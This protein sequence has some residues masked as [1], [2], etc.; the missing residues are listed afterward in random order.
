[1]CSEWPNEKKR[2][3]TSG[4]GFDEMTCDMEVLML[5]RKGPTRARR[6][7]WRVQGRGAA[8]GQ[9]NGK[10]RE[11]TKVACS[12]ARKRQ[13]ERDGSAAH[14][15]PNHRAGWGVRVSFFS[16]LRNEATRSARE[17][18]ELLPDRQFVGLSRH[19]PR[20]RP[21]LNPQSGA[22]LLHAADLSAAFSSSFPEV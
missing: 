9:V 7:D 16:S 5:W 4:R 15:T 10:A 8:P 2:T 14:A 11:S 6:C 17:M 18:F 13:R 21:R 20:H 22:V 19:R 3:A 12:N 1:M